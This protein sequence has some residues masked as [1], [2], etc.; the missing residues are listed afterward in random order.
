VAI[1]TS[2]NVVLNKTAF[3]IVLESF[4]EESPTPVGWVP[5][6]V[7]LFTGALNPTVTTAKTAFDDAE[8]DFSGYAQVEIEA[9]D[10]ILL[11]ATTLGL[12]KSCTFIRNSD[13]GDAQI[14]TGYFVFFATTQML[15]CE[16]F[17]EGV[18][19]VGNGDFLDLNIFVPIGL[20]VP[21]GQ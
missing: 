2:K 4:N 1:R 15:I 19:F 11:N 20:L 13:S 16:R 9:F 3:T 14:V 6:T 7:G 10:S 12:M 17:E 18:N 21:T 8:A 5:A